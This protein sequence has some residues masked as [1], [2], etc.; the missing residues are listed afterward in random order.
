MAV[1]ILNIAKAQEQQYFSYNTD[2]KRKQA[3]SRKCDNACT[4][5][6]AI[7]ALNVYARAIKLFLQYNFFIVLQFI[8]NNG[9]T[10]HLSVQI[11]CINSQCVRY[12][13]IPVTGH[14]LKDEIEIEEQIRGYQR[15][16]GVED[17]CK[18]IAQK[19]K[20]IYCIRKLKQKIEERKLRKK[21]WLDG[22]VS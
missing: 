9:H 15:L 2:F 16:Q 3:I 8:E 14:S 7:Q 5:S 12:C 6:K 11:I 4:S 10:E 18:G 1:A 20:K 17:D 21:N 22:S 13:L 19:K